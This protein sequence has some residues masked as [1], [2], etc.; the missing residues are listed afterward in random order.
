[1]LGGTEPRDFRYRFGVKYVGIVEP[2][3]MVVLWNQKISS[4]GSSDP[5][6]SKPKELVYGGIVEPKDFQYRFERFIVLVLARGVRPSA[7]GDASDNDW[8]LS[9]YSVKSRREWHRR[10]CVLH[11]L[12]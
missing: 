9:S 7:S 6:G 1:M 11:I 12:I 2:T 8:K 10:A 5:S 3:Y 4:T